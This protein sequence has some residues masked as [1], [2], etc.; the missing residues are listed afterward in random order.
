MILDPKV[1][2]QVIASGI[3]C[4]MP[5]SQTPYNASYPL[6]NKFQLFLTPI[7]IFFLYYIFL[8]DNLKN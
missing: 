7:C 3:G 5:Y 4:Q 8:I 6:F 1:N 2:G